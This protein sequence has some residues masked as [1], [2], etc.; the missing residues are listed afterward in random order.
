FVNP[1]QFAPGEDFAA[2]PREESAD[3]GLLQA[4]GCDL[5]FMP[6]PDEMY[7]DGYQ[8]E[9]TVPS[10]AAPLCGASRPHFFGGVA[11]VVCKLLNQCRPDFAIFGEK[12]FQQLLI[13]RRMVR[14]LDMDVDIVSA[15][16]VRE[17][18]GLAMSS[19]NAYL[20]PPERAIAGELNGVL[21]QMA[22]DLE[23]GET[24]ADA[25]RDGRA[26]LIAKGFDNIDYLE[27]RR[28]DDLSE[29]APGMVREA[30]RVFAAAIVGKTRLIDNW[31][32]EPHL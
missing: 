21:A 11:A 20:T 16:I 23:S 10:L 32:V 9:I 6:A 5:A 12:D 28:A 19:R 27:I 17:K 29:P 13:I 14:D 1:K 4:A 30:L 7:P 18:D 2:Y 25:L 26:A 31:P 3:L 24:I 22:Q 8:T 15:P